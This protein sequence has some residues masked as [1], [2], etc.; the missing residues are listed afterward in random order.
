MKKCFFLFMA[1]MLCV[2][3]YGSEAILEGES[4]VIDFWAYDFYS[5]G[6]CQ[7]KD[8][9]AVPLEGDVTVRSVLTYNGKEYKCETVP[10]SCLF[11]GVDGNDESWYRNLKSLTFE[12]GI[13]TIEANMATLNR[14]RKISIPKSVKKIG[15]LAL[16]GG[17]SS[18]Y[19]DPDRDVFNNKNYPVELNVTFTDLEEIYVDPENTV[20]SSADGILYDKD[21]KTLICCPKAKTGKLIIP[22]GVE[23]LGD[24]CFLNCNLLTEIELPSTL[25]TIGVK[26]GTYGAFHFCLSLKSIIIPEGIECIEKMSFRYC[27]GLESVVLPNTIKH[28]GSSAFSETYSLTHVDWQDCEI[29]TIGDQSFYNARNWSITLPKSVQYI[30]KEAFSRCVIPESLTFPANLKEISGTA[31]GAN[32]SNET[33]ASLKDIY[34]CMETPVEADTLL[35]GYDKIYVGKKTY[36]IFPQ[37]WADNCVLHVPYGCTESYRANDLWGLFH[38]IVEFDTNSVGVPSVFSEKQDY[39]PGIYT[40]TGIKINTEAGCGKNLPRGV[41]IVDGKKMVI[42]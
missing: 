18:G 42:K 38:N 33:F 37:K 21:M 2:S 13:V 41:Y 16:I 20:Y 1:I 24:K 26:N 4:V 19:K 32:I 8:Y 36:Y 5:D 23:A 22:E 3:S 31:F 6:T 17:I 40:I 30:G 15:D 35:F 7:M 27:A 28:I 34:L 39:R 12:D 25:K 9:L 29:D 11:K 10:Y 14:C